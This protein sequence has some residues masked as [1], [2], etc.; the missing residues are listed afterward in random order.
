M[1]KLDEIFR[2]FSSRR[3]QG[4]QM[5]KDQTIAEEKSKL[6]N[7]RHPPIAQLVERRTVEKLISV[8]PWFESGSADDITYC[9]ITIA[10]NFFTFQN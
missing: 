1:K 7:C 10:G 8:G 2:L 5:K 3:N 4:F 6:V 9:L